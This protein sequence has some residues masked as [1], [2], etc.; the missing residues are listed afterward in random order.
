MALDKLVDSSQLNGAL[1]STANAIRGKTDSQELLQWDMNEG[2]SDAVSAIVTLSEGSDDANAAASDLRV[3]KSAYVKG[4][5]I[6]G[7]MPD[8][9]ITEGTTTV[10]NT[11]ATRGTWSQT[12]GYTAARTIGAAAFAN[13]ATSGETYVDISGTTSAPVLVAGD[14]LYVNK[15]WTDNLKISLAKLVPDGSDVKG[16]QEYLLLGHSAYDN[17]GTLVAG[18]I[19]TLASTDLTV[20]G[21]TITIPVMPQL[22]LRVWQM[23]TIVHQFLH[24]MFQ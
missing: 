4:Q 18:T 22:S 14:Y 10:N 11:T 12:L 1:S 8:T 6:N 20:S 9:V 21:K 24:T 19:P 15:G 17:D 5:K 2:F 16:H 7:S 13:E 3:G 23:V